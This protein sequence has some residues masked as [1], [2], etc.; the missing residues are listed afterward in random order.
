MII[1][2]LYS[3]IY[4]EPLN[5]FLY[6]WRFLR[7]LEQEEK[8]IIIKKCY[9][10]FASISIVLIPAAFLCIVPAYIVEEARSNYFFF[11]LELKES[12]HYTAIATRLLKT[13]QILGPVT[14]LISCLILALVIRHIQKLSK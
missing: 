5:I 7:E 14:N 11:L 3:L 1:I 6:T 8:N 13:I 9:R 4:L 12:N 10:W 2:S